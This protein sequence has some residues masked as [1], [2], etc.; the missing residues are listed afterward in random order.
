MSTL[1]G[2]E[3]RKDGRGPQHWREGN[4]PFLGQQEDWQA[5]VFTVSPPLSRETERVCRP[6]VCLWP[7][8]QQESHTHTHTP[9]SEGMRPIRLADDSGW[10]HWHDV[11]SSVPLLLLLC[12]SEPGRQAGSDSWIICCSGLALEKEWVCNH[13]SLSHTHTRTLALSLPLSGLA[14]LICCKV[15]V[16]GMSVC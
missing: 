12:Y 2:W 6:W 1:I 15:Q 7:I 9:S 5:F 16:M 4:H 14:S 10:G 13:L 3:A 11:W 8:N